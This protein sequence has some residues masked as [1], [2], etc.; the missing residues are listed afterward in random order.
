MLPSSSK[1]STSDEARLE[2]LQNIGNGRGKDREEA[3]DDG[4]GEVGDDGLGE[5]G[6]VG[7]EPELG[8]IMPT[9]LITDEVGDEVDIIDGDEV[10]EAAHSIRQLLTSRPDGPDM[11]T[12]RLCFLNSL[13]GIPV[14]I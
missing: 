2:T 7:D 11:S 10:L 9:E 1:V 14:L 3:G 12:Q 4:L 5:V 8:D 6:E 13:N